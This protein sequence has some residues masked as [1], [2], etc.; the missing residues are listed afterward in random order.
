MVG[1]GATDVEAAVSA[2]LFVGFGGNQAREVVR[3]KTDWFVYDFKEL[4][5]ELK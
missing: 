2:D 1:D 4:I 5:D 3:A